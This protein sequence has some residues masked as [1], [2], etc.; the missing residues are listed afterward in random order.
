MDHISGKR[1]RKPATKYNF[2]EIIDI[3][4]DVLN[5]DMKIGRTTP[6]DCITRTLFKSYKA[7]I[8]TSISD[9]KLNIIKAAARYCDVDDDKDTLQPEP[10]AKVLYDMCDTHHRMEFL[11]ALH[12]LLFTAFVIIY[13]A[14]NTL[15]V[16]AHKRRACMSVPLRVTQHMF[17]PRYMITAVT[18]SHYKPITEIKM[19]HGRAAPLRYIMTVYHSENFWLCF[20]AFI[21]TAFHNSNDINADYYYHDVP[22]IY[23]GTR[24]VK[25]NRL[26]VAGM[27][28]IDVPVLCT[29][30]VE[31][32]NP[33]ENY[34]YTY[35]VHTK[36]KLE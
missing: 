2:S 17:V 28:S 23:S 30:R 13:S 4:W 11:C 33:E 26:Y 16:D 32:D 36:K 9:F 31:M 34:Y 25:Y 24:S 6:L 5:K 15:I 1:G 35:L 20:D 12:P 8:D 27:P 29:L 10:I 7:N 21:P 14:H 18:T 22:C 3:L 19:D